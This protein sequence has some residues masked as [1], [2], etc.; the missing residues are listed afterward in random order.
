MFPNLCIQDC[1]REVK[2]ILHLIYLVNKLLDSFN[3]ATNVTKSHICTTNGHAHLETRVLL[4]TPMRIS[5]SEDRQSRKQCT[6]A[7]VCAACKGV[8]PSIEHNDFERE[9]PIDSTKIAINFVRI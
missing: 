1:K 9:A 6:Q 2:C 4:T 8:L 5:R 7:S 3:D